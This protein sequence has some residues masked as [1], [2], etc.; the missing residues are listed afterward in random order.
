MLLPCCATGNDSATVPDHVHL[1]VYFKQIAAAAF[2]LAEISADAFASMHW[3]D[4]PLRSV[5]EVLV[6][7]YYLKGSSPIKIS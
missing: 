5:I 6:L 4:S 2:R 7:D 1:S 3:E